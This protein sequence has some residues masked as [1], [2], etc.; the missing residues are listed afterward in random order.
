MRAN[1]LQIESHFATPAA[2]YTSTWLFQAISR[3]REFL[4]REVTKNAQSAVVKRAG[5]REKERRAHVRRAGNVIVDENGVFAI[6]RVR[7]PILKIAV[8]I[9]VSHC[10][11][12]A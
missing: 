11:S 3:S 10:C 5:Q 12:S 9:G 7:T 6:Q 2:F 1:S 8:S 4:T